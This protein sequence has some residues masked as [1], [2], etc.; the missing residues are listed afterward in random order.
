MTPTKVCARFAANLE[1]MSINVIHTKRFQALLK[2]LARRFPS[3]LTE[4]DALTEELRQGER[5]GD[6]YRGVGYVVYRVRRANPSGGSGKSGGFRITYYVHDADTVALLAIAQRKDSGYL[7][8][9]EI[10]QLLK[11]AGF[12]KT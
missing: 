5:P 6:L 4:V 11:D 1:L 12:A 9:Y 8:R 2:R 10:D 3:A 7:S